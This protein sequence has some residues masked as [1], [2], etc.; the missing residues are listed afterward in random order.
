MGKIKLA[1]IAA[2]LGLITASGVPAFAAD[3]NPIDPAARQT[4]WQQKEYGFLPGPITDG[5]FHLG[6][7]YAGGHGGA[8][9]ATNFTAT[10]P[11]NNKM[12]FCDH[13]D[14]CLAPGFT[15]LM[16]F[17]LF[18]LC[19]VTNQAPCVESLEYKIGDSAFQKAS[20][21]RSPDPS[22]TADQISQ[23]ARNFNI[24]TDAVLSHTGWTANTIP[25][26]PASA[27]G[28]LLFE[29]PGAKNSAGTT[30]YSLAPYF[31]FSAQNHDGKV[32][33]LSFFDFG[34][35]LIP[36]FVDSTKSGSVILGMGNSAGGGN[37]NFGTS[38]GF[39]NSAGDASYV[40]QDSIGFAA[41]FPA[42]F[43]AKISMRLPTELGGWYQGRV[44]KPTVTVTNLAN[45]E[46]EV[47]LE[48]APV[49]VP[50]T[51]ADITLFDQANQNVV[52]WM[53]SSNLF[54]PPWDSWKAMDGTPAGGYSF[55]GWSSFWGVNGF[56]V[57][58]SHLGQKAK[59]FVSIFEFKRLT[60]ASGPCFSDNTSFQGLLTTNA[61]VY[62]P[63]LPTFS[64]G[65]LDY[66]VAGVHYD[67]NGEVFKGSYNF[68]MRDSVARCLYGFKGTGPIS[69]SVSVTSSDGQENVAYTNVNDKNGWLTLTAQGF[70]FSTPTIS[71]KLTQLSDPAPAP[72]SANPT[73]DPS[74]TTAGVAS[75]KKI[76]ITCVKGK[77]TKKV[78]AVN[79][80]CPAGYKKKA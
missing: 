14:R 50:I 67:A 17:G 70:T 47:V 54:Y 68:I 25:G 31:G 37:Y 1:A 61:M 64:S 77:L 23:T 62:Q 30:T 34:I 66:T 69:G 7:E 80:K 16:G 43:T 41:Q 56:S 8:S 3:Q 78:S 65:M 19:S 32:S 38:I 49:T 6:F 11:S 33:N 58:A 20:F 10:N 79:P 46:N 21:L 9:P 55:Y 52:D 51:S 26:L 59:G 45:S 73:P 63:D 39:D 71:A 29:L 35:N 72:T 28:P 15:N 36:T 42:D 27:P 76:T 40:A 53:K 18:Q 57:L 2:V 74:G 22:P 44:D 48:G 75:G 24:S 4:V 12:V 5:K 13:V 60:N